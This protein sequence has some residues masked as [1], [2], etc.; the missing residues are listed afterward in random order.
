[1]GDSG[2][3]A[4]VVPGVNYQYTSSLLVSAP[5]AIKRQNILLALE[6]SHVTTLSK[7]VRQK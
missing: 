4:T 6:F 2:E 7:N 1:M 3:R 5:F